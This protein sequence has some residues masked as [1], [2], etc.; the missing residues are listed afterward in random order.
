MVKPVLD[1]LGQLEE[2][3][4]VTKQLAEYEPYKTVQ[5]QIDAQIAA[6]KKQIAS[7]DTAIK[8]IKTGI[9]GIT[10]VMPTYEKTINNLKTQVDA[11]KKTLEATKDSTEK[12]AIGKILDDLYSQLISLYEQ[13]ANNLA[14]LG[15][16]AEEAI[17]AG[18][19]AQT[20][21]AER[22]KLQKEMEG[23]NTTTTDVLKELRAT[24][25]AKRHIVTGKQIGRAHV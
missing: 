17:K 10:K 1:Y 3:S 20:Y 9:Q 2:L 8:D 11:F 25:T 5:P 22:E 19:M 7:I 12:Q 24:I 13:S 21:R 15:N 23:I 16:T 18:K 4:S 6:T 14:T